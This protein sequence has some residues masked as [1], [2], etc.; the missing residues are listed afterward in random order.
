M[1]SAPEHPRESERLSALLRLDILDTEAEKT[2]DELTEIASAICDTPIS[3]I[4]LVDSERQWFKSRV[5]LDA[6][7]TPRSLAFC[8]HAILEDGVFEV[9]NALED[10]RFADNPLVTGAPDIR[11]YAGAPLVTEDGMPI[12]TLCV[13]DREPKKL[14]PTQQRALKVLANQVVGQLELR[15][16]NRRLKAIVENREKLFSVIAHDLR[17]PFNGILGFSRSLTEKA[18]K[19]TPARIADIAESILSSALK[20]YA[21]LDE[22]LQ[23]SKSHLGAFR[24]H[25]RPCDLDS[26]LNADLELI[27][28]AL[29]L[30]KIQLVFDLEDDLRVMAD[31]TLTK[32]VVRNLLTNAAKYAPRGSAIQVRARQ[33]GNRVRVSVENGGEPIPETIRDH[34]FKG[35]VDSQIGSGAESGQGIGLSICYDLM[36]LQSGIIM[37]DR[38]FQQGTRIIFSLPAAD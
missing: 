6:D 18:E 1:Q 35:P 31:P 30:K 7:Q 2:F 33:E 16:R 17:G 24:A 3:L 26:L 4:S 27:Q 14:T 10:Q 25:L 23:W 19:L 8:A 34:L 37:L 36:A 28:D 22:L 29:N 12:G 32:T 5:G 13:I 15:L 9:P 21:R 11:F 38:Q 20:V